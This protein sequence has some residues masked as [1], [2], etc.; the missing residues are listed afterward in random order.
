VNI[1]TV[2]DSSYTLYPVIDDEPDNVVGVVS[3]REIL[4]QAITG[5]PLSIRRAMKPALF[6][7]EILPVLQVLKIM[8]DEKSSMAI[9]IDEY[10]G[11]EGLLTNNDVIGGMVDEL[12]S[13][14]STGQNENENAV[15]LDDG[16]W[17]VDGQLGAHDFREIF[18]IDELDGEEN[19]RFET[20]AGY[21]LD[22]LGHIPAA[23]E[24]VESDGFQIEVVAMDGYRIDRIKVTQIA[25]EPVAE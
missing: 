9:V 16:T 17:L 3:T 11:V 4:H 18:N 22:R 21:V 2:R 12:G 8:R 23:G 14:E 6:V 7:P 5:E 25:G 20:I 15:R 19:G 24:Y 10:G 13:G 1:A